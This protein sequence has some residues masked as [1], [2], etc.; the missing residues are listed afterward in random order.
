MF[1]HLPTYFLRIF[2]RGTRKN[3]V[4]LEKRRLLFANYPFLSIAL[5]RAADNVTASLLR[6]CSITT[7]D[8]ILCKTRIWHLHIRHLAK[9]H[10]F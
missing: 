8:T 5:Q 9:L 4:S 7:A 2:K 1:L 6:A 3:K 10:Y